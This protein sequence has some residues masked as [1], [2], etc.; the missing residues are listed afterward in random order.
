M[1]HTLSPNEPN[2]TEEQFPKNFVKLLDKARF[3]EEMKGRRSYF[4]TKRVG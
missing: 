3:K 4:T 2:V 1:R